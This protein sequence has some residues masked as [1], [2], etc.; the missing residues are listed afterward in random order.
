[1]YPLNMTHKAIGQRKPLGTLPLQIEKKSLHELFIIQ[2]KQA[3]SR[4]GT[5][6]CFAKAAMRR[7][8][9]IEKSTMYRR[10]PVIPHE[11]SP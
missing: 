11:L 8:G 1:M 10:P 3:I 7:Q 2:N 4:T 5:L 9:G 6:P